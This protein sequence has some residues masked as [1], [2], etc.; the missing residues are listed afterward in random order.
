MGNEEW[1]FGNEENGLDKDYGV[2]D[3]DKACETLLTDRSL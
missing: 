3:V 2:H 1:E